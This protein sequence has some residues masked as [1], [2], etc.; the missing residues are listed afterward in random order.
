[1]RSQVGP[2]AAAVA[3]LTGIMALAPATGRADSLLVP[4]PAV[5]EI[6]F[7]LTVLGASGCEFFRNGTW[8]D[9]HQAQ[10]HL[11]NKY[12]W[13]VARDRVRSAE[14]FIDKAATRSS[15]S[16]QAYAVRCGGEAPVSS[17]SWLVEQLRRYRE[18]AG[19]PHTG[20]GAPAVQSSN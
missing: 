7:L 12:Q 18:A 17:N 15:L 6:N 8:Y 10:A 1:M 9:A 4:P 3:F 16:G 14:D 19:T 13:L 2:L 5:V 11:N 20:R